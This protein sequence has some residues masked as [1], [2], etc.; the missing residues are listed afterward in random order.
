MAA[1]LENLMGVA[2]RARR[3]ASP[4]RARVSQALRKARVCYD[5]LAGE[6]GV[7]VYD[8]LEQRRL[9]QARERTRRSSRGKA[10]GSF[11]R[12]VSTWQNWR[13][14]AARCVARA[15]IGACAATI[16]R[17]QWVPPVVEWMPG[18]IGA[19]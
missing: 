12:W 14:N 10:S 8:S 13:A 2:Y 4:A 15:W 1:L 9:L 5:H 7:L 18:W 11:S 19:L 6:L 16:S 17:A 3:D